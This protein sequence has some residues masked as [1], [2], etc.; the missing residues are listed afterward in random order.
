M[1]EELQV[2][3]FKAP[4][5]ETCFQCGRPVDL[6]AGLDGVDAMVRSAQASA[7]ARKVTAE[8]EERGRAK[9]LQAV[10]IYPSG[11][12]RVL[13]HWGGRPFADLKAAKDFYR[14]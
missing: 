10:V 9:G 14:P 4:E 6:M 1:S 8:S 7:D 3:S 12:V 2:S 13:Y 11:K 5:L